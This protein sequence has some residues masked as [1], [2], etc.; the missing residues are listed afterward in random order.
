MG[1]RS[2]KEALEWTVTPATLWQHQRSAGARPGPDFPFPPV[3]TEVLTVPHLAATCAR[4][5]RRRPAAQV[6]RAFKQSAL[7][8]NTPLRRALRPPPWRARGDPI[9]GSEPRLI[10]QLWG[11]AERPRRDASWEPP[12]GSVSIPARVKPLSALALVSAV[13]GVLWTTTDLRNQAARVDALEQSLEQLR[14]QLE[15]G[16]KTGSLEQQAKCSEAAARFF[17]AEKDGPHLFRA[18]IF[19]QYSNHYNVKLNRCF[20]LVE[21]SVEV[22]GGEAISRRDLSDVFEKGKDYGSHSWR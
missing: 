21:Y 5:R 16:P 19:M 22:G 2:R 12:R 13:V 8:G 15:K 20:V 17:D 10:A 14:G 9:R 4:C 1:E 6:T 18:P 11:G 7:F 3:G